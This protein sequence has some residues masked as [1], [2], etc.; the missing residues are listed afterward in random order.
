M[1]SL[2]EREIARS[3]GW[4]S[5]A[6]SATARR[7]P[8]PLGPPPPRLCSSGCSARPRHLR[9]PRRRP[10]RRPGATARD[11]RPRSRPRKPRWPSSTALQADLP[12]H[13]R[14]DQGQAVGI[15]ADLAEVKATITSTQTKINVVQAAYN[16]QLQQLENLDLQLM[17]GLDRGAGQ[18]GRP[19]RR[20]RAMLADH[21]R[22]AYDQDRTSVLETLLSAAS[23]TDALGRGRAT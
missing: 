21:I 22:A 18:G 13:H 6:R 7:S 17:V 20:A 2:T 8:S 1:R 23:F 3:D 11:R 14:R 9:R 16:D 12:R 10:V 4:S 15:N 19:G 5:T